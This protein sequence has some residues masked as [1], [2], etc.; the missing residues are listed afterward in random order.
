MVGEEE[1]AL[2]DGELKSSMAR[3]IDSDLVVC[4][5]RNE[6][7]AELLRRLFDGF[8]SLYLYYRRLRCVRNTNK[9]E[10]VSLYIRARTSLQRNVSIIR[11]KRDRMMKQ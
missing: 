1:V 6:T 9:F 3:P 11:V 4:I 7:P 5:A 10:Y 2:I 8:R